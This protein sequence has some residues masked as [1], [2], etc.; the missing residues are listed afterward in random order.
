[1]LAVLL[2]MLLVITSFCSYRLHLTAL[3]FFLAKIITSPCNDGVAWECP[4][5]NELLL[6]LVSSVASNRFMSANC[7]V[8]HSV[9]GL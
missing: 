3:G 8:Y 5:S 6:G 4:E 9:G 1:M 2:F 7:F